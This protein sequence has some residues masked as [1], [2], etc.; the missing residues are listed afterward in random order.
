[1]LVGIGK[2]ETDFDSHNRQYYNKLPH[3]WSHY[4]SYWFHINRCNTY[5]RF[6]GTCFLPE[7]RFL[8]GQFTGSVYFVYVT[9]DSQSSM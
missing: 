7:S 4:Q 3:I 2:C 6:F 8:I 1:M 9:D 5:S